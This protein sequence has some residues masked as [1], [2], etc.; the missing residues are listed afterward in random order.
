MCLRAY[1]LLTV[2]CVDIMRCGDVLLTVLC[3]DI[4][5]RG[6]VLLTVL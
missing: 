5:R 6:D 1:C 2:L 3:V 4:M